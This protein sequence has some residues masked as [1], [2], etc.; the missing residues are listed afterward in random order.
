[1]RHLKTYAVLVGLLAG[2]CASVT[3]PTYD[4]GELPDLAGVTAEALAAAEQPRPIEQVMRVTPEMRDFVE[5]VLPGRASRE[6][7]MQRLARAVLHPGTL[8][9]EYNEGATRTAEE[10]FD[11]ANGNC[12]SLSLLFV[13]LAREAGLDA[14]FH[15]VQVVPEWKLEGDIVFAARHINVGGRIGPRATYIMDFSPY[16]VRRQLSRQR[17]TDDAA[18]AQYY[19]NLGADYLASGDLVSAYLHFRAGLQLAPSLS[20]LWS[21][22][23]VA[24]SRNGQPAVAET[25]L[26]RAIE[27]D[28]DNT[29]AMTNLASLLS[30]RGATDEAAA[31][32]GDVERAQRR[33]PYYHYALG[34]R[35]IAREDYRGALTLL[36]Q[37]IS[38]QPEEI[39]FYQRAAETAAQLDDRALS[40]SYRRKAEELTGDRRETERRY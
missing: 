8:G 20:Y 29:S 24:Y 39:L 17:L 27:L 26:R 19:N 30:A 34:E 2:G 3:A 4:P 31:M 5:R 9:L 23:A 6:Q 33:N 22:V 28:A 14:H 40:E 7:R 32:M 38:L 10:A 21:N 18:F 12:L 35:A 13:A 36:R 1:M 16:L 37:A 15:Q 25:A 11:T